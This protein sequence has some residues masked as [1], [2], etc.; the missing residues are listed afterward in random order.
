MLLEGRNI[1]TTFP[2]H[3]HTYGH[4]IGKLDGLIKEAWAPQVE[5][6]PSTPTEPDPQTQHISAIEES[7]SLIQR[8]LKGY[9]AS[10]Y[11]GIDYNM[12][13]AAGVFALI[14]IAEK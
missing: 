5:A 13:C 4:I 7:K 12:M 14:A 3:K 9:D 1:D 8:A 2:G 6:V 11:I 10:G